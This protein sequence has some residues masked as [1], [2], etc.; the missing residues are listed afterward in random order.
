MEIAEPKEEEKEE[1]DDSDDIAI[2]GVSP[3][4][5]ITVIISNNMF[6]FIYKCMKERCKY[7][8]QGYFQPSTPVCSLVHVD[9]AYSL[10]A[11]TRKTLLSNDNM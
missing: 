5:K 8:I 11:F 7:C 4:S 6:S 1:D 3:A 10:L 2:V 9:V